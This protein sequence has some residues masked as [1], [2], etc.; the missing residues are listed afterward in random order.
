[1][2][3]ESYP[4]FPPGLWR[5]IVLWPAPGWI[6]GALEDDMHSFRI[7]LDHQGG[8]II[9]AY[10]RAVRT[11]WSMCPGAADHIAREL[12]G[13][14]LAGVAARDPLQHCTHLFDLAVLAAAHAQD[15]EP[16]TIDMRVADRIGAAELGGGRTTATLCV[17]GSEKMRWLLDGTLITG[18]DRYAG[19]DIK[20]VSRWKHDYPADEAEWATALRRAVFIAPARVYELPI[21]KTASEVSALRKGVC[22]NYQPPRIDR[23]VALFDRRDFS[24][25]G[26][27]PLE[28]IDHHAEFMAIAELARAQPPLPG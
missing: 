16:M 27:K 6:G 18:P 28:H 8:R 7:R 3:D 25:S 21:G 19:R 22:Y 26:R 17:N 5:R 9:A 11:P 2:S 13:E 10:A 20:R 15:S 14:L 4:T 23:S 12:T 1:M 24:M